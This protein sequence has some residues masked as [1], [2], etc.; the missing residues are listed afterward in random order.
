MSGKDE[1]P[2]MDIPICP[3]CGE[4]PDFWLLYPTSR[5]I[6]YYGWFRLMSD[7]YMENNPDFTKLISKQSYVG[8]HTALDRIVHVVCSNHG[9]SQFHN[10]PSGHLIF[11]QVLRQA[12]RF[13]NEW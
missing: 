12:K 10:F 11:D 9:N 13:N 5:Y 2:I 7:V 8:I 3:S 1:R 4:K 6:G